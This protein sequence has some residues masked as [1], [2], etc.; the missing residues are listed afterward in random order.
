MGEGEER[1][2]EI[3]SHTV[4]TWYVYMI[5]S[6]TVSPESHDLTYQHSLVICHMT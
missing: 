6:V 1:A 2:S 3:G 5:S 4:G